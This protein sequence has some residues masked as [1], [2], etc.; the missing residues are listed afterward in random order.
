MRGFDSTC[1]TVASSSGAW[2]NVYHYRANDAV[3]AGTTITNQYGFYCP[4][5]TA[6]GTI[7]YQLELV[8]GARVDDTAVAGNTRLMIYD[9]DN[10]QLERVTVGATDSGGAGYKVLRIPN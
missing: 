6:G 2:T 1:E 9:V 10:A 7:N 3:V 8:D 4:A 5:L